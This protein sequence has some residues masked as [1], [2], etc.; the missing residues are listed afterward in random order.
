ML[1]IYVTLEDHIASRNKGRER[2]VYINQIDIYRPTPSQTN[3][4][5]K[6]IYTPRNEKDGNNMKNA[7]EIKIK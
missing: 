2:Y 5:K 3:S 7:L 6:T 1:I 4:D